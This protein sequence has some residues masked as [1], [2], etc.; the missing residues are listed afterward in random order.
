MICYHYRAKGSSF[1]TAATTVEKTVTGYKIK[2]ENLS[3]RTCLYC[4]GKHMLEFF[5]LLEKRAQSEKI[6][7]LKGTG[8]CF[9]CLC[10]GH[11]CKECRKRLS[12]KTWLKAP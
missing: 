1:A 12:C 10:T 5:T 6:D 11:I 4:K 8:V 3:E 2:D 7:F 9:G